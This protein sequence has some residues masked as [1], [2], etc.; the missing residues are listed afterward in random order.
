MNLR[1]LKGHQG[2][3][4]WQSRAG[5]GRLDQLVEVRSA[6]QSGVAE[7]LMRGSRQEEMLERAQGPITRAWCLPG[8]EGGAGVDL[9][10][11]TEE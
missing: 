6:S 5:E 3:S 9:G 8:C 10:G 4:S 2:S 11:E 1:V 7:P